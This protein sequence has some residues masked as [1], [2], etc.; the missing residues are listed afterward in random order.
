MGSFFRVLLFLL[1]LLTGIV[2]IGIYWTVYKPLPN[3]SDTLHL[4]GLQQPVDV[5]WDPYGVPYIYAQNEDDLY[6]TIG[7]I[8]AQERLWQMTLSQLAAEGRFAEFLGEDL[9]E[10]DKYQRTLGFWETA[11]RIEE[12]T[13]ELTAHILQRYAD[14]VNQFVEKN[15]KNL[16]IEFTLLNVE[17]IEWTPTHSIA[18]TRLMAWD[19]NMHW[20]SELTFALLEEVLEP[21]RL[22]ELFPEYSDRYP[23]MM[24]DPQSRRMASSVLPML[25]K[26]RDRRKLFSIDGAPFGS[27]AWAVQGRKTESG[28]PI[29][30]G[31]PHMG[32]SIPGFWYEVHYS[33]PSHKITGATI[34]GTPFVILGRN[35]HLAW[36]ITNMMADVLDFFVEQRDPNDSSRYITDSTATPVA[37]EAFTY[38]S[39]I[40]KVR[41][42]DD[43]L[44]RVRE[45]QNGP[46]ISDIIGQNGIRSDKLITMSWTGNN[47]SHENRAGYLM[48]RARNMDEF[49]E[50]ISH[51]RSPAMNFVYADV[52]DNIAIFSTADLPIRD[53]H[54]LLF[55]KG[56]DP[57]Y[58]WQR[59]I[60]LN[61]LPRIINPESG[62]VANANNKLHTENYPHY[63]GSFWAPPS[64]IIR[65]NDLLRQNDSLNTD[66]M[67]QFQFDAFSEHARE[68][69]EEIVPMLRTGDYNFSP[70]ISYLENWDYFFQP[71]STAAT[72]FDLFFMNFAQNTL[73]DEIGDEIYSSL[74][75]LNYLPIQIMRSML[76]ENSTFFNIEGT[77]ITE[78]RE[79]IVRL[80]MR[81]TIEQ[82]EEQFGPEPIEW[83]WENAA[84]FT[85]RPPLLG[86][87]VEN[88]DA[89]A[90]LRLIV[91]NIFSK[92]PY[93]VSG[94]SMSINKSDYNW[95][96][97]FEVSLG[98]SIRRIID[99]SSPGRSL[100]V[101]PTG[102]SGNP[103]S[104]HYGDQTDLWLEG[105]YRFIYQDS[106]FFQ[107]TSYQT[108]QLIPDHPR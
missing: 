10:L 7:Y 48:N 19:Q 90:V 97:P 98:P 40:I 2:I 46:V 99:F 23:T 81:E 76:F 24:D 84:R 69:T 79:E 50:A 44:L 52:Q 54:P 86:E 28:L 35:D 39:E 38:R 72:I 3:Y 42:A 85:L 60:P 91:N 87:A 104:T 22:Q 64:R 14:G 29:L 56:W 5:H 82:L 16:P 15:R 106:T 30:A 12:E 77:S 63:I 80:T 74:I 8:H 65:I 101:L 18:L 51:F 96:R 1:I 9:I 45:T 36:S 27:N 17:P 71:S 37:T 31:D 20:W 93:A 70:V 4:T 83:R 105:R 21:Q 103:F 47:V 94:H 61:E 32:L 68:V 102:Q 62:F 34:A 53:H 43:Q 59:N 66:L 75:S 78:G 25:E 13:D 92:G 49:R 108:M 107:Q 6:F 95:N 41:G 33:T 11:N 89:P 88:P 57:S 58:S 55:R 73:K 67:Q 100:S 26:E